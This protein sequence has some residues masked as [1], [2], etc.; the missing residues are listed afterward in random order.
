MKITQILLV[1][2]IMASP[3]VNASQDAS[4]SSTLAQADEIRTSDAKLSRQLLQNIDQTQLS[5]EQQELYA[6]LTAYNLSM[7]GQL[8]LAIQ[9]MEELLNHPISNLIRQRCLSSLVIWYSATRQWQKGLQT[10][11]T[12]QTQYLEKIPDDT[13]ESVKS[14]LVIFYNQLEQFEQASVIAKEMIKTSHSPTTICKITSEWLNAELHLHPKQLTLAD[15]DKGQTLCELNSSSVQV[16][17]VLAYK[18]EYLLKIE[19]TKTALN[20]LESQIKAVQQVNY[21]QLT[22]GYYDLILQAYEKLGQLDKAAKYARLNIDTEAKHQY[23]PA[24]LNANRVLARYAEQEGDYQQALT[25]FKKVLDEENSK[26]DQDFTKLLAVQNAKLDNLQKSN[27]IALLDKQNAL[28]KTQTALDKE[29]AQNDRLAMALLSL[30][31]VLLFL[32]AYKNRR[33]HKKLRKLAETDELTGIS[34]RY[35]FSQLANAAISYSKKSHQ[36]LCFILFDLD[37]FKKIND[38]FGHQVGDW[39]LKQVVIAARSVCRNNDVIGRLGGEEFGILLPGCSMDKA[40]ALAESC[41]QAIAAIN[42]AESG[43]VFSITA[44]FGIAD[45]ERCD[46]DF[47]KLFAA[48]DTALYQ[49]KDMGRNKVYCYQQDQLTLS[50]N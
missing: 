12:L 45:T 20:V 29:T 47:D 1:C 48:A 17:I 15:F 2:L 49:S 50:I 6:Y 4:P 24:I 41:R 16:L 27:Q 18:A 25:Y 40:T 5:T 22:A 43:H 3:F 46:Y 8:E 39:A 10:V 9:K 30:V 13:I 31:L 33:M 38:N 21:P 11:N 44:S 23:K 28:L 14:S 36:S 32:W 42:S 7:S 37:F 35:H 34:N 26:F 19:Q